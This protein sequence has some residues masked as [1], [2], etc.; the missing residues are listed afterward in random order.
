MSLFERAPEPGRPSQRAPAVRPLADRLRPRTL[1]E[2][3]GQ[4]HLLGAGKALRRAIE[5][6]NA[7]SLIL[8]GPPGVGKTTLA[9]LIAQNSGL[10]FAPFSA[11]L[12]GVKELREAVAEADQRRA[13]DGQGTLLFVDEIHR[14][15]KAQQDA[16]LPFVESGQVVLLGATNENPAFAVIAPLLSRSRVLRL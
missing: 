5:T 9:L 16:L 2:Y 1:A 14:F 3:L 15:N 8:F 4:E 6:G 12:A 13:R 7:G 11:V 10:H